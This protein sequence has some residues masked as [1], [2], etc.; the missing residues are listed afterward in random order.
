[1]IG[2]KLVSHCD[3]T[4][5]EGKKVS[6]S[7]EEKPWGEEFF[8]RREP[9]KGLVQWSW[10]LRPR[11]MG[12]G[13]PFTLQERGDGHPKVPNEVPASKWGALMLTSGGL[14]ILKLGPQIGRKILLFIVL[15]LP[16]AI[17]S[18]LIWG[19]VS[20]TGESYSKK[21]KINEITH[22]SHYISY[23]R[24]CQV[25]SFVVASKILGSSLLT[26]FDLAGEG[27]RYS[28]SFDEPTLIKCV[29]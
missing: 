19:R 3:G 27:P 9:G 29:T 20:P 22:S 28:F 24:F 26:S 5:W 12:N 18:W 17:R 21:R 15:L 10:G 8:W 1:M 2:M 16:L 25:L 23:F 7:E 4:E 11:A 13:N 6:G 14:S